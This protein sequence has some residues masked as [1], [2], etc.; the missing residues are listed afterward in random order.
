MSDQKNQF[1]SDN[2]DFDLESFI[3]S[4]DKASNKSKKS[5]KAKKVND[6]AQGDKGDKNAKSIAKK[7]DKP[8]G[9]YFPGKYSQSYN[10]DI[11]E[12]FSDSGKLSSSKK[13]DDSD[14]SNQS[15]KTDDFGKISDHSKTSKS[16][17]QTESSKSNDLGKSGKVDK[18]SKV[19]ES[20]I[21]SGVDKPSK[22]DKSSEFDKSDKSRES[23]KSSKSN[24]YDKSSDSS[25]L[26]KSKK[27]KPEKPKDSDKKSNQS[28]GTDK[29]FDPNSTLAYSEAGEAFPDLP[30]ANEKIA[31]REV[32]KESGKDANKSESKD[33]NKSDSKDT[34]KS[35]P[36]DG[37]KSESQAASKT[38]SKKTDKSKNINNKAEAKSKSKSSLS[39]SDADS[40]SK[41]P[42][43]D[44][45]TGHKSGLSAF[46]AAEQ[47]VKDGE[48]QKK[49]TTR[50]S[51]K[52]KN[53]ET[54]KVH[55]PLDNS[56]I[57]VDGSLYKPLD[58]SSSTYMIR[59]GGSDQTKSPLINVIL[60]IVVIIGVI[61]LFYGVY[62]IANFLAGTGI[63][64]TIELSPTQTREAIDKQ[65]PILVDILDDDFD[66]TQAIL[67]QAGQTLFV[68]G[69]YMPDSPDPHAQGREIISIPVEM[70]DEQIR[71]F[72]EGAYNAYSPEELK[73]F[74]NGAY[75]LDMTRGDNGSWDK[76]KYVNFSAT[77][78]DDEI[79]RLR[80]VQELND[81]TTTVA[82]QGMDSR[83]NTVVQGT[84]AVGEQVFYWK[85]AACPFSEI[86]SAKRIGNAA[87]YTTCT[88]ASYDF[89]TGADKIS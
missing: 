80:A 3:E 30:F 28:K 61:V 74:F 84:K 54:R 22:S 18:V 44:R 38:D 37:N 39:S 72:Y 52:S 60:A 48:R 23:D 35:D 64:E 70:D 43:G 55:N 59:G 76:I 83:G 27:D 66:G 12:K 51:K 79:T 87:V 63:S 81:D 26:D 68:N 8:E 41:L 31:N 42:H 62:N 20:S 71:G 47:I 6:D 32:K 78:I 4:L 9:T 85:I 57:L 58:V 7:S 29:K 49:T 2:Q 21:S 53:I 40:K 11:K 73:Q 67:E 75:V 45:D 25:K 46:E 36:K 65:L 86:Y 1:K 5:K 15:K 34:D 16:N 50:V 10:S 88:V 77:G 89:Y 56:D 19:S 69:R 82:A 24:K 17:K 13:S 14:K 33:T